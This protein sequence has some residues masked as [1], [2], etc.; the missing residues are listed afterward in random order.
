MFYAINISFDIQVGKNGNVIPH[1]K[2][3]STVTI[4]YGSRNSINITK[5]SL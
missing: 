4:Y 5:Y 2:T 1:I 3:G